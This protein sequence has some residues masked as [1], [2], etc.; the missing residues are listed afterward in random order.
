MEIL[1]KFIVEELELL[2]ALQ[3]TVT[4]VLKNFV[5]T[6][7]WRFLLIFLWRSKIE[8]AVEAVEDDVKKC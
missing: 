6:S 4:S 8:F 1:L 2:K 7:T 3:H 5:E